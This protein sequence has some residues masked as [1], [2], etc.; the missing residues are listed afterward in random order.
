MVLFSLRT[1]YD[2]AKNPGGVRCSIYDGMRTIFGEKV[3][4]GI[5]D[6]R[7]LARSPHDNVG[8]QYGLATLHDG[9][10]GAE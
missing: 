10:T 5:N 7:L 6:T 9:L 8:V 1:S 3:F 2:A 4:T